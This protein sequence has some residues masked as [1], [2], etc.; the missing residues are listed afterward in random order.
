MKKAYAQLTT[1]QAGY[2]MDKVLY[3]NRNPEIIHNTEGALD[4]KGF[5]SQ[6]GKKSTNQL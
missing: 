3:H 5:Q 4:L 1:K 6:V 2:L